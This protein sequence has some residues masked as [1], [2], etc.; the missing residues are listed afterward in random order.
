[1]RRTIFLHV[2]RGELE[3]RSLPFVFFV[4]S[5]V[6]WHFQALQFMFCFSNFSQFF[7]ANI[8]Y[9]KIK[10]K[11]IFINFVL[12]I[13]GIYCVEFVINKIN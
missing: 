12:I 13:F 11:Y 10:E 6:L 3:E 5:K 4:A 7:C 9:S 8:Y 1:M 2:K